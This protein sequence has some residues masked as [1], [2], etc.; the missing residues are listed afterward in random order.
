MKK[1]LV[2]GKF[3]SPGDLDLFTLTD[4]PQEVIDVILHY[5]HHVGPPEVM[6]KAFA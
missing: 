5:K 1:E 6:P 2:P 4:D 3:I